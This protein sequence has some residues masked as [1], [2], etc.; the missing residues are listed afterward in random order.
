VP[1]NQLVGFAK[2]TV[3]FHPADVV[4]RSASQFGRLKPGREMS[5]QDEWLDS[6]PGSF[7][8]ISLC[9]GLMLSMPS[10]RFG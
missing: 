3:S 5:E 10:S 9:I 4:E 7:G 2:A 6:A 8:M 1:P